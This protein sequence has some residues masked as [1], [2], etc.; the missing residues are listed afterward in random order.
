MDSLLHLD[1]YVTAA[2]A[3]GAATKK[4]DDEAAN[5]HH[6]ELMAAFQSLRASAVD[7][8]GILQDALS[9][10]DPHV[11]CWAARHL[12]AVRPGPATSTLEELA[13]RKG[14]AAFNAKM[15]LREWRS[16]R[17]EVS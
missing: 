12:L 9:D 7:W 5:R 11:R 1:A 15:V 17:L 4:G 14:L 8:P 6:D 16:G 2:R 13:S 3:H 10:S